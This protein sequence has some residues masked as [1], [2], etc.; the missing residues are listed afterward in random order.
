MGNDRPGHF[1]RFLPGKL[2]MASPRADVMQR[3]T[4]GRFRLTTGCH[5]A[6]RLRN[7][8]NGTPKK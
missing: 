4:N 5:L 2:R 3:A 7:R 1:G 8:L 6:E